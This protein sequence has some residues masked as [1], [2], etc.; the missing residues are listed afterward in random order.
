MVMQR[1]RYSHIVAYA[2][3]KYEGGTLTNITHKKS[4]EEIAKEVIARKWGDYPERK[5]RL[6]AEGYNYEEI[7]KLVNQ[8]LRR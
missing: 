4:N 7:R 6:E 1:N 2:R 5:Q 8:M 3:P